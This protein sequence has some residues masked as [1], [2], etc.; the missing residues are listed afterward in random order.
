MDQL[1]MENASNFTGRNKLLKQGATMFSWQHY[2]WLPTILS[3]PESA[4]NNVVPTTLHSVFIDNLYYN[5]T[6]TK[7][8]FKI[9]QK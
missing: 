1:K 4:H 5:Y 7:S 3:E 8:I 6:V 2:S 9:P